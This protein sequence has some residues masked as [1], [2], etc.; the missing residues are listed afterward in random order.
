MMPWRAMTHD[1]NYDAETWMEF[2]FIYPTSSLVTSFLALG[3]PFGELPSLWSCRARYPTH[4]QLKRTERACGSKKDHVHSFQQFCT[5]TNEET[6]VKR[7]AQSWNSPHPMCPSGPCWVP[8][9]ASFSVN[10]DGNS[11][12]D[13]LTNVT[14]SSQL[15]N[16]YY[17][18]IY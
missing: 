11:T 2:C 1:K 13:A 5:H 14:M 4:M 6:R 16:C 12:Q 3:F 10:R 9:S 7:R 17:F 8:F 15:R 18:I